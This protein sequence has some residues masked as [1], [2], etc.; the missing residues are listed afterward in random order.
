[1]SDESTLEELDPLTGLYSRKYAFGIFE[2]LLA[3]AAR[4]DSPVAAIWADIDRMFSYNRAYGMS[5]GDELIRRIAAALH[6]AVGG[7]GVTCRLSGDEFLILL[8]GFTAEAAGRKAEEVL[9]AVRRVTYPEAVERDEPNFRGVTLGVAAF[10][11]SGNDLRSV[12]MAADEALCRGKE[13]GRGRVSR[14]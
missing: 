7:D 5:R 3:S 2:R 1:M 13:A 14:A 4:A 10:P 11:E 9:A 12:I 6:E 8:P